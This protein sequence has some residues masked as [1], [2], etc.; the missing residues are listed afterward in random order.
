MKLC[1]DCKHLGGISGS[2]VCI[3]PIPLGYIDYVYGREEESLA[4]FCADERTS[5]SE[6]ACG[7]DAVF[8]VSKIQA[9]DTHQADVPLLFEKSCSQCGKG[10]GFGSKRIRYF[11]C[12]DHFGIAGIETDLM[13]IAHNPD[14]R[15]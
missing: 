14:P 8:F 11:H 5:K 1:K 3:R 10:F 6:H 15:D 9:N 2:G 13:N 12:D 4:R 7:P